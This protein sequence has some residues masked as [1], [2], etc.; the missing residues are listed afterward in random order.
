MSGPVLDLSVKVG[1]GL[2]GP[3]PHGDRGRVGEWLAAYR[4]GWKECKVHSLY[5]G[6]TEYQ[7][8]K[9]RMT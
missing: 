1:H 2:V 7:T 9:C 8:L 6:S 3:L 4:V 5:M